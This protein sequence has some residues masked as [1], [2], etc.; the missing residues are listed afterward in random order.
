M[1]LSLAGRGWP[2]IQ[3]GNEESWIMGREPSVTE[4]ACTP[5]IERILSSNWRRRAR[6][7]SGVV[8]EEDGGDKLKGMGWVGFK[9]GVIPPGGGRVGRKSPPPNKKNRAR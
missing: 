1:S 2:S 5:G 4:T 3:K 7:S 8:V 9:P 6:V